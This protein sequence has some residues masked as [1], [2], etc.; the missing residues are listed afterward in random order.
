MEIMNEQPRI[1]KIMN[2]IVKCFEKAFETAKK[3]NWDKIYIA[4][5]LHETCL[6]PTWQVELS[7]EFYPFA[8]EALMLLSE[9]KDICLILWSCSLPE[10]NKQ[11]SAFFK[12][13]NINFNYINENPECK[14]TSYADFETKLYFSVGL[15]DKFGFEIEDWQAL[16]KYLTHMDTYLI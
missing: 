2:R 13:N 7:K 1:M 6:K 9:R 4:V 5:D 8:K 15:D 10:I 14:S 12:E 11:Y 3:K 16:Y